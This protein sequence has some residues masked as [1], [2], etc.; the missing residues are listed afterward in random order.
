MD[1]FRYCKMD[2]GVSPKLLLDIYEVVWFDLEMYAKS[3]YRDRW[4]DA[5]DMAFF[6]IVRNFDPEKGELKR[7]AI[8]IIKGI[9]M[10]NYKKELPYESFDT[11]TDVEKG[12]S[13]DFSD[14]AV[15]RLDP[16][17][18]DKEKEDIGDEKAFKECVD[19]LSPL[20]I[21]DFK[22]FSTYSKSNKKLQYGELF[23]KFKPKVIL[24][25]MEY[26]KDNYSEDVKRFYKL[27][28]S[29]MK[30][31]YDIEKYMGTFDGVEYIDCING[32]VFYRRIRKVSIRYFYSVNLK[33]AIGEF[34][35]EFYLEGK[36]GMLRVENCVAYCSVTGDILFGLEELIESLENDIIGMISC[37]QHVKVVNY[38]KGE[39]VI[40][41]SGS[42]IDFNLNITLFGGSVWIPLDNMPVKE[43]GL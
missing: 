6:H 23:R 27:K 12:I 15:E 19:F 20:F 43:V 41:L 10:G 25:S 18:D 4:M 13:E 32:T 37:R 35:K 29:C 11:L 8:K 28:A 16:I 3:L 9:L 22:F 7:Y 17:E 5:L 33:E 38:E 26:L 39:R 21:K 30:R 24:S 36:V 42:E 1:Y 40:L 34:I 2:F 31:R 14:E